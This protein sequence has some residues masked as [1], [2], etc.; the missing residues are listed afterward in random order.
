MS[1]EK[2]MESTP[3]N[4]SEAVIPYHEINVEDGKNFF[5][6][7]AGKDPDSDQPFFVKK[8][9]EFRKEKNE[10]LGS[11]ES[12]KIKIAKLENAKEKLIRPALGR[13]KWMME[14]PQSIREVDTYANEATLEAITNILTSTGEIWKY[15]G[16]VQL[17]RESILMENLK[18][19]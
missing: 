8:I 12:Q 14:N 13:M 15:I 6:D 10:I 4:Y 9:D 19:K 5:S 7:F 18:H 1:L 3:K 11:N 2:R 16:L 17:L